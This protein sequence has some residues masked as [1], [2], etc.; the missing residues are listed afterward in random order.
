MKQLLNKN[1]KN[2]KAYNCLIIDDEPHVLLQISDYISAVRK[3]KLVASFLKPVDGIN[4]INSTPTKIDFLF[5]DINMQTL[6]GIETAK[7]IRD[8]VQF[9]VFITAY[10]KYALEAFQVDCDAF[11]LKPISFEKLLNTVNVLLKKN[12]RLKIKP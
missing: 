12:H 10:E 6:N 2:N 5:L 7:I 11:V 1:S 4:F 9:L 3:L 8:K